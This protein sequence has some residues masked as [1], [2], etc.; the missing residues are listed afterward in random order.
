[1][2]T[3]DL[4]GTGRE[5]ECQLHQT[6]LLTRADIWKFLLETEIHEPYGKDLFNDVLVKK[7]KKCI[8]LFP[9]KSFNYEVL[10]NI[11]S[12]IYSERWMTDNS[13]HSLKLWLPFMFK[14]NNYFIIC[15]SCIK[16]PSINGISVTELIIVARP[17]FIMRIIRNNFTRGFMIMKW[18]V[19]LE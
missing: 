16:R 8:Q 9:M 17:Y 18:N 14:R 5:N 10:T 19:N 12:I 15:L 4:H 1:M 13:F 2:C 11:T 7:Y 6:Y 3:G